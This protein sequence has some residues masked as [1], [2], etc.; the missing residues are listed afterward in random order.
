MP[1][2]VSVLKRKLKVVVDIVKLSSVKK[3]N[4]IISAKLS[5]EKG[6][7]SERK[8]HFG[9]VILLYTKATIEFSFH[10]KR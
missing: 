9:L 2:C 6:K 7:L 3:S 1:N 4:H 8:V 10:E 5:C